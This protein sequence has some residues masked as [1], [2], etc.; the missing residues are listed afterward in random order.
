MSKKFR[1][2]LIPIISIPSLI[3]FVAIRNYYSSDEAV[4]HENIN[5]LV[6]EMAEVF[7]EIETVVNL[8][9]TPFTI[10]ITTLG[11]EIGEIESTEG[12]KY[13]GDKITHILGNEVVGVYEESSEN[14]DKGFEAAYDLLNTSDTIT[15][16]STEPDITI[17]S[18]ELINN[19]SDSG[20][21]K[22]VYEVT[23]LESDIVRYSTS[24]SSDR[25]MIIENV[26]QVMK[27]LLIE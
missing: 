3:I 22:I 9:Q 20:V 5:P 24:I 17:Y 15:K 1:F 23:N 12:Y 13:D 26:D 16:A 8:K 2:A 19:G 4:Q 27:I 11:K 10:S 18:V 21:Y 25:K 7:E 6:L 14:Y